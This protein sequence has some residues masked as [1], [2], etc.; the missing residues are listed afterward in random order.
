VIEMK[1]L[2]KRNGVFRIELSEEEMYFIER[3][4]DLLRQAQA[5]SVDDLITLHSY[6]SAAV[7]SKVA[8]SLDSLLI[9]HYEYLSK[10]GKL[11]EEITQAIKD[12]EAD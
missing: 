9:K 6:M 8:K 1:I 12:L 11:A 5:K 2:E 3:A 7:D 4:I 10:I